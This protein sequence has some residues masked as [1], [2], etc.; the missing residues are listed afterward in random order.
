MESLVAISQ[1]R[2]VVLEDKKMEFDSLQE[3]LRCSS[4][5]EL[6]HLVMQ[7][8]FFLSKPIS[9]IVKVLKWPIV[10]FCGCRSSQHITW[11][12]MEV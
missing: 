1:G 8:I 11:L 4:S 6:D 12:N 10:S 9:C 5:D 7:T 2:K 3:G